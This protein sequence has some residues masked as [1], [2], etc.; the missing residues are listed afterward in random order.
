MML[1]PYLQAAFLGLVE[2]LTEFI[3]VS[4]TGHLILLVDLLGFQ[5]PE[6][7][8]FEIVIQLGAILAVIVLYAPTLFGVVWRAP[9]DPAA[10]RFI[11]A[12]TIAFLPAAVVGALAH[13]FIK[14]VLFSPWVVSVSLV[15]GGVAILL[16]ERIR[17]VPRHADIG[18]F[19]PG[20]AL[21][22]GACQILAMV[23][24]VS[25]SGATI[26]GALLMGVERKTAAEFSFF[27]AIP[28]MLGATVYDVYKNRA[29][30]DLDGGALIAVGFTVAFVAALLVVRT[31]IVFLGRHGFA[32]F[33][34]YRIVAGTAMFAVLLLG[35][36]H[37]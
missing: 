6:G 27:L 26:M 20:L 18:A 22:I 2:G 19:S 31:L 3:P 17:P 7:K 33:A 37:G 16:I 15:V 34:W 30:L 1:V 13:G 23:P 5:G 25:R 14:S 8:V 11:L 12:V 9:S 32:P 35:Y 10:R 24:G 29:T 36:G 4:S 28:T 21:R